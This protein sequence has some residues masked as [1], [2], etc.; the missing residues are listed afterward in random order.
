[1]KTKPQ[2]I[3][4]F[5]ADFPHWLAVVFLVSFAF[6]TAGML[7]GASGF[8]GVL[9]V[10]GGAGMTTAYGLNFVLSKRRKAQG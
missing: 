6:S 8:W 3:T 7:F 9:L 4:S 2:Q 1:M 10:L 5:I